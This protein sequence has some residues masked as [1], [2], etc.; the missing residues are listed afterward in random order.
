MVMVDLHCHLLPGVDDGAKDMKVSLRL[1]KEAT[2]NGITHA[3]LTPHHLNGHYVNHKQD[4]LERTEAFQEELTAHQIPLTVFP[5]QEVR[6]NGQ[7]MTALD[8]DDI[9][10]A[11]ESGK[12]MLLEFPDDDVPHYTKQMVFELQQRGI[13]PI[14]VHP[15]RNTKIMAEPDL[16]FELLEKGCLSQITASSYVGTFGKKV[17]KFSKDLIAGGQ[18]YV[19]ASDAHDLPGRKYEMREAFTK[20]KQEFGEQLVQ[21]YQDN[22]RAIINGD[23][24][25]QH[26]LQKIQ[27]RKKL[28]GLF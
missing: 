10:F 21:E 13:V 8:N 4:V 25:V 7:L 2:E 24:V 12:Y 27:Q 15:E 3:L 20:L 26:Q 19:F 17:A 6:I 9:L 14:I 18:G 22:A 11:D 23:N 16:L 28:F 5:G 1:A